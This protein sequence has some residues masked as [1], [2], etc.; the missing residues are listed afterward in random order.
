M[1]KNLIGK[2]LG[3][4]AMAVISVMACLCACT[5]PSGVPAAEQVPVHE[6]A[7]EFETAAV[8]ENVQQKTDNQAPEGILK[9]NFLIASE[10]VASDAFIEQITDDSDYT[11]GFRNVR[12]I[13]KESEAKE[14]LKNAMAKIDITEENVDFLNVFGL[15]FDVS[16]DCKEERGVDGASLK[17]YFEPEENGL[18]EMEV[19]A[20]D[21]FGNASTAKVF[22]LYDHAVTTLTEFAEFAE[23]SAIENHTK[24]NGFDRRKAEEAFAKVNEQRIASGAAALVWDET[25]YELAGIRAQELVSSFSHQR[26]DGSYVGDVMVDQYGFSGCGE[27]IAANYTSVTNLVNGWMSSEGHRDNLLNSRFTAGVMSCYYH[28]GS[29]YWVNLFRS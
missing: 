18:Y 29:C 3:I 19:A 16:K 11:E 2:T 4:F 22:V 25:L 10:P 13:Y 15:S 14:I 8:T 26:P 7:P 1:K 20:V 12:Q 6:T 27:N 23:K 24:S 21:I 5:M 9:G 17:K 28:N